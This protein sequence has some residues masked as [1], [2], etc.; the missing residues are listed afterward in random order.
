MKERGR[1]AS[2]EDELPKDTFPGWYAWV[3][4]TSRMRAATT[5]LTYDQSSRASNAHETMTLPE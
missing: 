5:M 2:N 4:M 3:A 1:L